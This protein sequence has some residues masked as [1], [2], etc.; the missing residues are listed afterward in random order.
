MIIFGKFGDGQLKA[1]RAVQVRAMTGHGPAGGDSF[2]SR[3]L[4]RATD[5]SCTPPMCGPARGV[6]FPP[7]TTGGIARTG[8]FTSRRFTR[9]SLRVPLPGGISNRELDLLERDLSHC[10]QRPATVSNRELSTI[11]NSTISVV[12]P[13]QPSQ[14]SQPPLRKWRSRPAIS[15]TNF[16][17]L[18]PF[19]TGSA[20]Q[21]EIAVTPSK[22]TL[23]TSLTGSRIAQLRLAARQVQP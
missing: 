6:T 7:A 9:A 10:K 22:Q 8:I 1:D 5:L 13:A 21:T 14:G 17:P 20:S 19:L 3:R 15:D 11:R 2:H 23:A 18:G 12:Q 16:R 4:A